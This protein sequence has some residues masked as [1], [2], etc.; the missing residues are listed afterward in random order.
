MTYE[1]IKLEDLGSGIMTVVFNRPEVANALSSTMGRE[2]LDAWTTLGSRTDLR[3]AAACV[4]S[5]MA[6]GSPDPRPWIAWNRDTADTLPTTRR[7]ARFRDPCGGVAEWFKAH[8][9][10]AC[11]VQALAGSNPAPSAIS[12][13]PLPP[14][15]LM[16]PLAPAVGTR[17]LWGAAGEA[18]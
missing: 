9:W 18:A 1:T 11:W 15:A 14:G 12:C 13:R 3:C 4:S 16:R 7:A 6:I 8:A 17:A 2:L 5:A 10:K